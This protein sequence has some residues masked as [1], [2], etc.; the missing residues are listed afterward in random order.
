MGVVASSLMGTRLSGVWVWLIVGL[1]ASTGLA[2][3]TVGVGIIPFETPVSQASGGERAL[4]ALRGALELVPGYVEKG[5]I[6]LTLDEARLSY[7]CVDEQPACLGQVGALVGADVLVWGRLAGK[8]GD[9]ALELHVIEVR[10]GKSADR[11]LR[12]RGERALAQLG[13]AAAEAVV[14]H[15]IER[16]GVLAVRSLPA[17]ALVYVD[18]MERGATPVDL[19]L[20]EGD[21]A[22]ELRMSGMSPWQQYVVLKPGKQLVDASLREVDEVEGVEVG[23][24]SLER[25][26]ASPSRLDLWVTAAGGVV[27]VAGGVSAAIFGLEA[28]SRANAAGAAKTPAEYTAQRQPFQDAKT[29]TNVSLGVTAVGAVVTGVFAYRWLTADEGE[30]EVEPVA[31]FGLTPSGGWVTGRF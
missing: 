13:H 3:P 15:R 30:P 18:G 26:E 2:Q 7:A 21:Y 17:G 31:Q 28:Q 11:V 27:T 1:W 19:T 12:E 22:L 24:R 14:G 8:D 9:W 4:E 6:Q 29:M 20:P 16:A 23:A 10:E 25:S 5:P